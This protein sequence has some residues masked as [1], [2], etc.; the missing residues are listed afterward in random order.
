M[1]VL[2]EP[3]EADSST[4]TGGLRSLKSIETG[5]D[6][7]GVVSEATLQVGEA[8]LQVGEATT[9]SIAL[10]V[11][12]TIEARHLVKEKLEI[13]LHSTTTSSSLLVFRFLPSIAGSGTA[14]LTELVHA[15]V[16]LALRLKGL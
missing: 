1:A 9:P 3:A 13:R 6:G 16:Q 10:L 7:G 12:T 4:A 14:V 15:C 5:V 8:A 11:E 2:V